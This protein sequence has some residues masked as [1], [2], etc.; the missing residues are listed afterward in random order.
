M[1]LMVSLSSLLFDRLLALVRSVIGTGSVD[2]KRRGSNTN[3]SAMASLPFSVDP[4]DGTSETQIN[5]IAFHPTKRILITAHE[6][7]LIRFVDVD[8]GSC[9]FFLFFFSFFCFFGLPLVS[10][11]SSLLLRAMYL[12]FQSDAAHRVADHSSLPRFPLVTKQARSSQPSSPTLMASPPL[13]SNTL[14]PKPR[15]LSSSPAATTPPRESGT[16]PSLHLS[17]P[18]PPPTTPP[19]LSTTPPSRPS[20]RPRS[21]RSS[22]SIGRMKTRACWRWRSE[23]EREEEEEI[24]S[25]RGERMGRS[26]CWSGTRARG[27]GRERLRQVDRW[28]APCTRGKGTEREERS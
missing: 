27:G 6:D 3:L 8:S 15:H 7:K 28:L 26:G 10:S 18:L 11:T 22:P 19:P 12:T 20:R 5:A 4:K 16:S 17:P 25:R 9:L 13:P 1:R 2:R 14:P 23:A 24:C 21:S